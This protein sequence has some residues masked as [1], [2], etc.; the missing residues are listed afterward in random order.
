[1]PQKE[2]QMFHDNIEEDEDFTDDE[3]KDDNKE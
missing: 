3:G 2:E 1:M